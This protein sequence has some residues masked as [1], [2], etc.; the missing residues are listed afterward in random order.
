M[1]KGDS[2]LPL[3]GGLAAAVGAG[4]CC[5]G[6]F[7]L[8]SLGIGGAWVANLTRFE[9]FR[10]L[11]ILAALALLAWAGWQ[12]HRPCPPDD[13]CATL[14]VRRRRRLIFWLAAL[15][16]LALVTAPYWIPLVA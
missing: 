4:L 11:F 8:V 14:A 2:R 12:V 13:A 16:A 6:P 1:P 10:P 15:V 5:V 7:V 9:P 3:F